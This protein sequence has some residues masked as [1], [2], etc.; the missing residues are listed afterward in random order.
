MF[1]RSAARLLSLTLKRL[2]SLTLKALNSAAQGTARVPAARGRLSWGGQL[3]RTLYAEGV[4][5][6]DRGWSPSSLCNAFGVSR[7]VNRANV[8][9]WKWSAYPLQ[10]R[11]GCDTS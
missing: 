7:C 4:T 10:S 3:S 2:V 11:I 8:V 9:L 5:H 6:R 1:G